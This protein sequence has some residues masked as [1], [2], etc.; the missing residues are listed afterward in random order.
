MKYLATHW[1]PRLFTVLLISTLLS[2]AMIA[3]ELT[4][5]AE[6]INQQGYT[7]GDGQRDIAPILV[8]I[9]PFVKE[10]ILVGVPLIITLLY[11]KLYALL[12]SLFNKLFSA[13]KQNQE[14]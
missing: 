12:K 9:L 7:H 2:I 5:W 11:L 13:T 6:Q 1:K 3:L 14:Q 10:I 8:Y 4:P